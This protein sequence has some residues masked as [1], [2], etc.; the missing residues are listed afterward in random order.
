MIASHNL[1]KYII[2]RLIIDGSEVRD[3][4]HIKLHAYKFYKNLFGRW[5]ITWGSFNGDLWTNS[6]NF[7]MNSY[8]IAPFT[9]EEIKLVVFSMGSDKAPGHDDFSMIFFYQI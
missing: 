1:K 5:G 8:L 6:E 4:E 2:H 7:D 3:Q 9:M